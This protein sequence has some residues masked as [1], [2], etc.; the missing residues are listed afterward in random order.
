MNDLQ[1]PIA[2]DDPLIDTPEMAKLLDVTPGTLEVWR[3]T[4][5]YDLEYIKVG[6]NVRYRKSSGLKFLAARTV[7]A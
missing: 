1:T 3:A 2:A 7:S 4:K 5:R 6:R